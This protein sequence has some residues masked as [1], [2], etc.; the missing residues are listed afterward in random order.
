MPVHGLPVHRP[1]MQRRAHWIR[2]TA[3]VFAPLTGTRGPRASK[4]KSL[5]ASH[6]ERCGLHGSLAGSCEARRYERA[7]IRAAKRHPVSKHP[8]VIQG[9]TRTVPAA[10]AG[11]L[12]FHATAKTIET[13]AGQNQKVRVT[14]GRCVPEEE[15]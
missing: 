9:C 5:P 4:E 15:A 7:R 1:K 6:R 11:P 10:E 14:G 8:P 3:P 13:K 2:L 12:T